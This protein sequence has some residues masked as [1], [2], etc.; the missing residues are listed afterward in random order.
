MVFSEF[1]KHGFGDV[2]TITPSLIAPYELM[3][4]LG[5][6]KVKVQSNDLYNILN[7]VCFK[8]TGQYLPEEFYEQ[9]A[10]KY[11]KVQPWDA[12]AVPLIRGLYVNPYKNILAPNSLD[13]F[14]QQVNRKIIVDEIKGLFEYDNY[15]DNIVIKI[16]QYLESDEVIKYINRNRQAVLL[17]SSKYFREIGIYN[18]GVKLMLNIRDDDYTDE[19]KDYLMFLMAVRGYSMDYIDFEKYLNLLTDSP[20]RPK[21]WNVY[22]KFLRKYNEVKLPNVF[23]CVN[24]INPM[25]SLSKN[26]GD[27][28]NKQVYSLGYKRDWTIYKG[29]YNSGDYFKINTPRFYNTLK[30]GGGMPAKVYYITSADIDDAVKGRHE[31]LCSFDNQLQE[32]FVMEAFTKKGHRRKRTE[33]SDEDIISKYV[34]FYLDYNCKYYLNSINLYSDEHYIKRDRRKVIDQH[35]G[36]LHKISCDLTLGDSG[37]YITIDDI[38]GGNNIA[39]RWLRSNSVLKN[40]MKEPHYIEC[41]PNH[42]GISIYFGSMKSNE[43]WACIETAFNAPL[44]Y[45]DIIRIA[46]NTDIEIKNKNIKLGY[47]QQIKDKLDEYFQEKSAISRR[48][49]HPIGKDFIN[50][51]HIKYKI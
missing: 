14:S 18:D 45:D 8:L 6:R 11:F 5:D 30:G 17:Y 24:R 51:N 38:V 16:K 48:W 33:V 34:N 25:I 42:T 21:S 19:C 4:E 13:T 7:M 36:D 29:N 27:G 37:Y 47:N 43:I 49:F 50:D 3:S 41:P 2:G 39:N 46:T 20:V 35:G 10:W 22:T 28:F 44:S 32:S 12:G 1:K 23:E 9:T 26:W 15:Y 40:L 31:D